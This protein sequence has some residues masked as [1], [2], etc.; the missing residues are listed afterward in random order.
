MIA[1]GVG[2]I[3]GSIASGYITDKFQTRTTVMINMIACTVGYGFLILYGVIYD[4][5]FYLGILMTLS[6][7]VQDAGIN[8]LLNSLLGFQFE[9]KTTP[10]SV[11]KF[12]QSLLIFICVSIESA[13]TNQKS[14]L[15]YFVVCYLIA[16]S[17]WVVLIR[18]F[19]FKTKEEVEEMRAKS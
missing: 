14:Y 9:S 15:I 8:C 4:F 17:A 18:F 16:I 12:L 13:T 5:T 10:F 1:L 2:E 7:G 11:Y 19:E 3:L 6:W